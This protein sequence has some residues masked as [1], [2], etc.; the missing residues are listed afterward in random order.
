MVQIKM[1]RTKLQN[2]E[3]F[4]FW[5]DD[6]ASHRPPASVEPRVAEDSQSHDHNYARAVT[7]DPTCPAAADPPR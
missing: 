1:S 3:K 5:E 2:K 7:A 6:T 4:Q